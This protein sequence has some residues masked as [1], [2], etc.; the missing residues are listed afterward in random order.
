MSTGLKGN[1]DPCGGW[2]GWD[3]GGGYLY[4]D[5]PELGPGRHPGSGYVTGDEAPRA[6]NVEMGR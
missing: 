3:W 2:L 5:R 4:E 1:L 6:Q